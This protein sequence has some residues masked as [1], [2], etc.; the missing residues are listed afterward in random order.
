MATFGRP[1]EC[2][3]NASV[4]DLLALDD[5]LE[6]LDDLK[7]AS[8]ER[9]IHHRITESDEDVSKTELDEAEQRG[10]RRGVRDQAA[11]KAKQA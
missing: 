8:I 11:G 7:R 9:A 6:S 10:Y 3:D 1:F 5:L 2:T 4:A